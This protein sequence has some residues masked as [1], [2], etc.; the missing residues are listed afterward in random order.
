MLRVFQVMMMMLRDSSHRVV[1]VVLV[2]VVV[3]VVV[4]GAA[5]FA[6]RTDTPG[7]T[8]R[9]CQWGTRIIIKQTADACEFEIANREKNNLTLHEGRHYCICL[10]HDMYVCQMYVPW[11]VCQMYVCM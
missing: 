9:E 6:R 11:Y 7:A 1:V 3:V 4:V 5:V 10:L 2:V 8:E